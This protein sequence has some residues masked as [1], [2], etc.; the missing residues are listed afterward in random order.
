M[1]CIG[2]ELIGRKLAELETLAEKY[3]Q[4][5]IV[6]EVNTHTSMDMLFEGYSKPKYAELAVRFEFVK[7]AEDG[8]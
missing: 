4:V 6:Q 8:E 3:G 2:M 1:A 7:K 5:P